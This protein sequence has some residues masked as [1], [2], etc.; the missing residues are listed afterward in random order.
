MI[1][2]VI[3]CFNGLHRN[4]ETMKKSEIVLEIK[5]FNTLYFNYDK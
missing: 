1:V 2:Y 5:E 3:H 4:G